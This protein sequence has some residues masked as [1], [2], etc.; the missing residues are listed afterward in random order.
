M[1][2]KINFTKGT[3][4]QFLS[5]AKDKLDE[6]GEPIKSA[7]DAADTADRFLHTLIGDVDESLAAEVDKTRW[8]QDASCLY[9]TVSYMDHEIDFEI[10]FEDL[11]FDF[12]NIDKDVDYICN[13]VFQDLDN[14]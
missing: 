6:L 13:T 4:E 14:L 3:P 10:P 7:E 1:N 11:T 2:M 8:D 12:N 5:L 9:L